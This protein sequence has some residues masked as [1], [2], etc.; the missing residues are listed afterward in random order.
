M[1]DY[2]LWEVIVNGDSPPLMRIV[3]GVEQ[4]YPPTTTEEKLEKKNEL[5]ARGTLLMALLNEHQLKFNSYKNSKSLMEAIEKR[6]G[7]NKESKKVHKTL[8]KQQYE[9]FNGN[10]PE[11][12]DQIYDRLQKLISQLEINKETI[13]QEDLSLNLSDDVIYS[14][15]EKQSNSPQLDNEDLQQID[16]DDLEE[17]DLKGHFARECKAPRENRNRETVRRNMTVKTTDANDLVAQDRFDTEVSTCSKACLKSYETLKEHYDNLSKDNK[18]SQFNVGAYKAGLESVKARVDV[19]KKNEAVFEEDIK[20]LKIDI[21]FRDN[22][23]TELRKKFKKAKKERDDLKLTLEKFKNSSKNLGKL[24]DSQVC[25]KF[26]TGVGFDSQ[27]NDR[28]MNYLEEQTDGEAMINSIKN[29]DQ[30]LPRVTQVP[31][32]RTTS[33]E[34]PP[35]KDKSMWSAQEKRVQ[36]IDHLAR[37]LLI[38]GLPNDIYSLIDSNKTAKDLWDALARHMLGSEYGEQDRKAAV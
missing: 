19:Y 8:L 16:A 21:M 20:I 5:K 9:N 23:L 28:F 2:V 29:G 12:L 17:I 24:L 22:V 26:K 38:Q 14:F 32:A 11:G 7:G 4:S 15:F 27:V 18:K 6:F 3:N 13:S 10:S 30:P 1:T 36:K 34:Q 35:L 37:Y 31:I 33:T 25:D